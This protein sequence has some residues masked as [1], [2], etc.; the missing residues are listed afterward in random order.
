M[1]KY[2]VI[3]ISILIL[4][5]IY[6]LLSLYRG[7][8]ISLYFQEIEPEVLVYTAEK[9]L[10]M[11]IGDKM[12]EFLIK[13][14]EMNSFYPGHE[15]S[16]YAIEKE[17][18]KKWFE[19]I[20]QMGANTIKAINRFDPT[21]YEALYEFNIENENPLYLL[22]AIEIS[23]YEGNNGESIYG[24]K[25]QL[26][27]EAKIAVDVIHGNRYLVTAKIFG[28][29]FYHSDVSKWTLGYII[30]GIGKE[31]TIAFTDYSNPIVSTHG[32]Y[33]GNYFYTTERASETECIIA[34]I[35]DVLV[36]YETQKYREQ[37][38]VSFE[39][40]MLKDPL[41]YKENVNIQLGKMCYIDMNHIKSKENLKS[42][43]LISYALENNIGNFSDLIDEE[44]KESHEEILE[45]INRETVY[46]GYLEFIKYYYEDPVLIS[47]F[48]Y[49]T[50]RICEKENT[51]PLTEEEQGEKM[52]A[53]YQEIQRAGLCGGI[54]T[55]WQDNWS[56]GTWN[57]M[58]AT[59][60]EN[61][62]FWDNKQ[63]INQN[64]GLLS[65]E[66][67]KEQ[68]VCEIDGNLAEWKEEEVLAETEEMAL[69]AKFDLE[70][71]YLM[72]RLK[73]EENI[74]TIYIPFDITPNSGTTQCYSG[75]IMM[76]RPSDFLLKIDTDGYAELLVQEYYDSIRAMYE[77]NI[78]GVY[79]YSKAPAKDTSNF[80][81]LRALLKKG[82]D[83]TIDVSAMSSQER[84]E[85]RRYKVYT[86]GILTKGNGNPEAEDY[87]SL[88][89]YCVSEDGIEIQI[90]WQLLN[91]S[92][93]NK[94]LIHDDYYENYGVEELQIQEIYLGIGKEND[95][96]ILLQK[97]ELEAWNHKVEFHERLKKSYWIMKTFWES[98]IK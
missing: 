74:D 2:L 5:L 97:L 77:R 36:E 79:Q 25:A 9:K 92:S 46:G 43:K 49:S 15:F 82:V 53:D 48:G 40:D 18:Y 94:M 13:G 12:E 86:T 84:E 17:T 90:P 58:Y 85:Y 62:I 41:R 60:D 44:E 76:S 3:C 71:I 19:Q 21:F 47:S 56:L 7:T 61:E 33:E 8:Y 59:E 24:F 26:M 30:S 70:N 28:S 72:I 75:E 63:S 37:K 14:V 38:L 93:P 39:V 68:N 45:R 11:K 31:E 51:L 81:S 35:L 87:N 23:E 1:K 88:A 95:D 34:E 6:S 80:V 20:K 57:T 78:T 52:V 55:S 22:Q 83:S 91:F 29:G 4:V 69:Y 89:D 27:E 66:P 42:G 16:E 10:Y 32:G 50:S 98:N 67:G 64:Y 54:I 73:Q 65:F 96:I